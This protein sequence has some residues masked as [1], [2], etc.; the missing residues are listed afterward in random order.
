MVLEGLYIYPIKSTHRVTQLRSQVNLWGLAGDRRW[1][2]VDEKATFLTQREFPR[3]SLIQAVPQ[4]GNRLLLTAAGQQ[5]VIVEF[6]GATASVFQVSIW[7]DSV[8]AQIASNETNAWLTAFLGH[9]VRLVHMYDT[10][11]RLVD[12]AYAKPGTTVSFADGYP[13][14]CTTNASLQEL[15]GRLFEPVPME[16]F[17]PNV[18]VSGSQPFE[19]DTW[20]RLRIGEVKFSVVKPCTRCVITTVDQD[21]ASQGKEPLRTLSSFRKRNGKVYFGENLVP[22]NTGIIQRGDE[23]EVLEVEHDLGSD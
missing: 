14:L 15:N 8:S 23:V 6:P 16:R 11:V 18:V 13:L 9:S 21:T 4:H 10:S 17:R 20:K 3:M 7:R 12:T 1:M 19:E 22:E 2:I 5:P